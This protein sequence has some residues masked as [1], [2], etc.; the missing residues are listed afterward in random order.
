[1]EVNQA[2]NI[3]QDLLTSILRIRKEIFTKKLNLGF[4]I[5]HQVEIFHK[6]KSSRPLQK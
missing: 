1:M 4:D 5:Q 2:I 6:I 3:Q